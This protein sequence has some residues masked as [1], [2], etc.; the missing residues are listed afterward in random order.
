M[1][2]PDELPLW[3]TD[4]DYASGEMDGEPNKVT[5]TSGER[6]QGFLPNEK[7]P[8]RKFNHQL[9]L[10]GQ[11]IE[12]LELTRK[13]AGRKLI[14]QLFSGRNIVPAGTDTTVYEMSRGFGSFDGL[15]FLL[16]TQ[17]G[18]S[19]RTESIGDFGGSGTGGSEAGGLG[20]GFLVPHDEITMAGQY[21]FFGGASGGDTPGDGISVTGPNDANYGQF[22][23][24][25]EC[26]PE[27]AVRTTG[28]LIA[29]IT[30]TGLSSPSF[31]TYNTTGPT[32]ALVDGDLT[33]I[34]AENQGKHWLLPKRRRR[35]YVEQAGRHRG[36]H[37]QSASARCTIL[38]GLAWLGS[39]VR[40][41]HPDGWQQ[42]REGLPERDGRDLDR[43]RLVE[44]RRRRPHRHV[45]RRRVRRAGNCLRPHGPDEL[46]VTSP[47]LDGR[48]FCIADHQL[49]APGGEDRMGRSPGLRFQRVRGIRLR[50]WCHG[51]PPQ[52]RRLAL[53]ALTSMAPTSG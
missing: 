39:A 44:L 10:T 34:T 12:H 28:T 27:C 6:A 29:G 50:V 48:R 36:E 9:N 26:Q 37:R 47:L 30:R 49:S 38:C 20:T 15:T 31:F 13:E 8:P 35:A 46:G 22:D 41:A 16:M 1:A 17:T 51:Q 45:R 5:F 42:H 18:D 23:L 40:C 24:G 25:Y 4:D 14:N 19:G 2:A 53:A 43:A 3:A 33:A 52:G 32:M 11:W 7:P 21:W